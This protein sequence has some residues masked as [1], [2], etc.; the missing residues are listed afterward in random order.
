MIVVATL[1]ITSYIH[2]ASE[3][4]AVRII[5][6]CPDESD[7]K[8]MCVWKKRN[9]PVQQQ[10]E[11]W[12]ELRGRMDKVGPILRYIFDEG[13]CNARIDGC[14]SFVAWTASW[15]IQRYLGFGT[16][17]LWEGNKALEYLARIV[18]VRGERNGESPFNAPMTAHLASEPLCMLAQLMTQAEFNLFVSRIGDHLIYANFL[19]GAPCLHF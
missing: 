5:M 19:G 11:Y 10:A 8:A 13:N 12:R 7:V 4:R 6:N 3:K 15:E 17:K 9:Q 2:W 18:R 14:H 1:E 16:S